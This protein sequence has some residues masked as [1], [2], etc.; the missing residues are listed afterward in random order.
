MILSVEPNRMT[1][2]LD[3]RTR[4]TYLTGEG[5]VF[6]LTFGNDDEDYHCSTLFVPLLSAI[7]S[8]SAV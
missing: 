7:P 8:Q 5:S 1:Y 4:V 3:S 2:P 6:E